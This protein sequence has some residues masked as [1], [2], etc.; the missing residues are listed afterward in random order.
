MP[1]TI[2]AAGN[3]DGDFEQIIGNSSHTT[4]SDTRNTDTFDI[5]TTAA[6]YIAA[7]HGKVFTTIYVYRPMLAF[8][9][10][11]ESGTVS[12]ADLKLR[13]NADATGFMT[14]TTQGS[15]HIC[16]I[17]P[18]STDW[19]TGDMDSLDGWVSSGT[20][21]GNVTEYATAF[22]NVASTSHT[23]ALNATAISDLNSVI[24][25]GT[26]YIS[27]L[28]SADFTYNTATG[29]LGSP[30]GSSFGKWAG[31]SFD[32]DN[33]LVTANRPQ[34]ELTY[35]AATP[36]DNSIIFGTNF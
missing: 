27:L 31:G 11:R 6:G 12:S 22:T 26:F 5:L 21:S 2:Y 18:S 34:I 13:S 29:Y 36:T 9:L 30:P 8:D 4:I 35:G 14:I 28:N 23:V 10:S 1:S 15:T 32:M 19:V 24:G 20:Y 7:W 33:D 17:N 16:K 3:A 25:S